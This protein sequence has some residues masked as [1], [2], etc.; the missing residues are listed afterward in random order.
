[1]PT[2]MPEIDKMG[3]GAS[4]PQRQAALS[5]CVAEQVR[6]GRTPEEAREMCKAM[7]D[8][9]LKGGEARLPEAPRV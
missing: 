6:A 2:G 1:M 8:E 3:A 5:A 4:D 9:Q 7:I